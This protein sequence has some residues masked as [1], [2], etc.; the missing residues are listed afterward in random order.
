MDVCD[1][2]IL[3]GGRASEEMARRTGTPL[4]ALFPHRGRTFVEWVYDALRSSRYIARIAVIGPAALHE[5]PGLASCDLL[6]PERE[7]ITA[8]FF[9]AI[10][11]LEPSGRI[12]ITASDNP[13][14]TTAAFDDFLARV[15]PDAAVA[16]PILRHE[17]FLRRFPGATNIAIPTREGAWIGGGCILID[18]R[19]LPALCAAVERVLA[20]RKSKWRMVRLLGIPFA[21]R[22]ATRRITTREVEAR[23]SQIVG[24]PF[25]FVPDSAPEF[26]IDI[27]DPEDWDYLQRWCAQQ[28]RRIGSE[29]HDPR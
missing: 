29:E 11:A 5:R 20:A 4:R 13:L 14:L 28:E 26:P 3:A 25:R 19:V 6:L 23:A 7:S 27:D 8:N 16:Y 12:L 10:E 22:F 18:S 1:A 15:P 21:L 17:T 9:A 24:V 2:V